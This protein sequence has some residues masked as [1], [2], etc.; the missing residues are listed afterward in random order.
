M[1]GEA[2]RK[3]RERGYQVVSEHE[4]RWGFVHEGIDSTEA[5]QSLADDIAKAI[6]EAG[7]EATVSLDECPPGLFW[8]GD[9]LGFKSEYA[10]VVD[11]ADG[12]FRQVDAYVVE[13]GE[14]FQGGTGGDSVA[15]GKLRVVPTAM[16]SL[17]DAKSPAPSPA[18]MA[19]GE[20]VKQALALIE[21]NPATAEWVVDATNCL[22]SLATAIRR[23]DE[24]VNA[25][26]LRLSE[27]A[28]QWTVVAGRV[29]DERNAAHARGMAEAT[30]ACAQALSSLS[31]SDKP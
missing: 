16:P 6:R 17:R 28:D 9:M 1:S 14:Y 2:V 31:R 21:H 13:S 15:R 30:K 7:R 29:H 3:S 19:G 18:P 26:E 5:R 10:T 22:R 25:L 4:A 8:F 23:Q 24:A 12:P 27:Q 20:L 11:R